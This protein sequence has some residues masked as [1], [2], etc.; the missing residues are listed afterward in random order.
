LSDDETGTNVR[1]VATTVI[2]CDEE[3]SWPSGLLAL[4]KDGLD[5]LR[6]YEVERDRIDRLCEGD[7]IA[8]CRP[9]ANPYAADRSIVLS[10]V[11]HLVRDVGL[12]GYHCTR[13]HDDEIEVIRGNGLRPLSPELVTER[14]RRRVDAGDLPRDIADRLLAGHLAVDRPNGGRRAGMTWFVFTAGP[15]R[16]ERGV[17]SLLGYW[18]GEAVYVPFMSDPQVGPFLRALGTA[19]IVEAVAPVTAIETFCDVSERLVR[20]YLHRR[21]VD[22]DQDPEWEGYVAELIPSADV[23]RV[24]KRNDPDFERL[25]GCNGWREPLR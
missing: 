13:L 6:G 7:I 17:G 19:C 2:A 21:G 3:G 1:Q 15:L 4:L 11:Q 14:I 12:I 18:G 9:P 23:R 10:E 16:E 22:T 24:I 5:V 20:C 8:R 25:T